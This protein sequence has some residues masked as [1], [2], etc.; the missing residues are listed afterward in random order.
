[1]K[2]AGGANP[3]EGLRGKIGDLLFDGRW[4]FSVLSVKEVESYTMRTPD[5][6]LADEDA[7]SVQ[8]DTMVVTPK[9][10]YGLI[11][12]DC[13]VVNGRK[14]DSRLWVGS[15]VHNAIAD[16]DGE[17]FRPVGYDFAGAPVQTKFLIPGSKVDFPILFAIPVG[18]TLQDLVFTLVANGDF[19]HKAD[20]RVNLGGLTVQP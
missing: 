19:E 5:V 16:T 2:L 4:R 12:V 17:A 13:H 15:D 8:R 11:L 10:G 7:V 14:M 9:R 6:T 18:K 3:V 20:V 1:M